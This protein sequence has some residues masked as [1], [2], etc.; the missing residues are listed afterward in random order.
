MRSLFTCIKLNKEP[1]Y[2][3]ISYH[4]SFLTTITKYLCNPNQP[5]A[6][7]YEGL[8]VTPLLLLLT[9]GNKSE[10]YL[11]SLQTLPGWPGRGLHEKCADAV[12]TC[13]QEANLFSSARS[14]M[15]WESDS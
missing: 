5:E 12:F 6:H 10:L 1:F 9:S 3:L 15:D 11:H 7:C 14:V 13:I 4:L 8:A 2:L